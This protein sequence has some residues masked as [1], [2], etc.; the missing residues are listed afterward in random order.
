MAEK[1][2]AIKLLCY[3]RKFAQLYP[4]QIRAQKQQCAI[5]IVASL[6]HK[7]RK[8]WAEKELVAI[9]FMDIKEAF[10]HMSKIR[11]VERMMAMGIDRDLIKWIRSFLTDRKI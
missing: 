8:Y 5:D 11:L 3:Y 1:I 7:V 4:K 9:L 2:V 10:D 6:I